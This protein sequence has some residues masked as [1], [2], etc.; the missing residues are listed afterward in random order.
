MHFKREEPY[1]AKRRICWMHA[2]RSRLI[3]K[4]SEIEDDELQFPSG[5]LSILSVSPTHDSS[6]ERRVST[7]ACGHSA[8]ILPVHPNAAQETGGATGSSPHGT[9][10]ACI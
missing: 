1:P 2:R 7:S 8:R 4:M 6:W 5:G 10:S 9:D 3:W